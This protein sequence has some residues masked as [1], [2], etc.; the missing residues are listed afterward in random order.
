MDIEQCNITV[1]QKKQQLDVKGTP[2]FP[3][4]V[5]CVTGNFIWHW[6]KELE[7]FVVAE[8]E[9]SLTIAG[10]KYLLQQ[11]TGVFINTN[12]LHEGIESKE[13]TA[14]LHSIVFGATLIGGE[15]DSIFEQKYVK[16]IVESGLSAVLTPEI[17]WQK[18]A[19]QAIEQAFAAYDSQHFGYECDL[20]EHLTKVFLLL[21]ENNKGR[22]SQPHTE[23]ID[24]IR[25]RTMLQYIHEQYAGDIQV[26][27]LADMVHISQRE[28]L[29][30]FQKQI[31]TSPMQYVLQYRMRKAASLLQETTY[32][33]TEI[34]HTVGFDSPSYFAKTFRRFFNCTP[35]AYRKTEKGGL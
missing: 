14:L 17:P 21:A 20:R 24:S 31:G 32:T 25:L 9:L 29:R 16:P 2:L 8:G 13:K 15:R 4:D 30:C 34:C 28:C 33:M 1:D 11:G 18:Q 10:K 26:K 35:S 19:I 27:T 3:C 6:H 22:L 12:V 5:H 23:S 7:V